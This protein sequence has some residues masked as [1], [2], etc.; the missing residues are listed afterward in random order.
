[1]YIVPLSPAFSITRYAY[2]STFDS[3]SKVSEERVSAN[4]KIER[5]SSG[6]I[7]PYSNSTY[8]SDPIIGSPDARVSFSLNVYASTH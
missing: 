7:K 3:G 5:Y 2:P 1:M 8:P 4:T 6:I